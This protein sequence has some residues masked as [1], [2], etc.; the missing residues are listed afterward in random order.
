MIDFKAKM[1]EENN[2]ISN[3]E[4]LKTKKRF[5][6][7]ASFIVIIFL[8][9]SG[10]VIMSSPQASTW[11]QEHTFLGKIKYLSESSERA[12]LG[13]KEDRINIL[14]L[15]TG[16]EGHDGANLADT[17]M[18]VS[19]KPSTQE[20]ALISFPRD[21]T[22]PVKGLNTW[23][24]INSLNA[25]GEARSKGDGAQ[26][27]ASNLSQIFNL[28]INYFIRVDFNTFVNIIDL[29]NG[30]TVDVENT[31]SDYK[32]PISG[33]EDNPDYYARFEHL[34]I[35]KGEQKMDGNLALKFVRSRHASGIEG[36]D[37]ARARRQQLVLEAIKQNLLSQEML[38]KPNTIS[39]IIKEL[40]RGINTNLNV[41]ELIKLWNMFKDVN[42]ENIAN[43]VF[44]DGPN[45]YLRASRGEQNAFIL[46][47]KSGNFSEMQMVIH[48]IFKEEE[49]LIIEEEQE[50][51]LVNKVKISVI[52]GS[53]KTGLAANT[54]A[55]LERAGF[56]IIDVAN[57]NTRD[58]QTNQI[59]DLNFGRFNSELEKLLTIIDAEMAFDAPNWI[60]EYKEG[61]KQSDF[62]LILGAN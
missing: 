21:L 58:Y 55:T 50:E 23:R 33:Q 43:F 20:V 56:E 39:K 28:D 27:T 4:I 44:D 10:K 8:I 19:F 53:W 47:P 61:D 62:V 40:D 57:A 31:L 37:F 26:F 1:Q 42:K 34:Y 2:D 59:Y 46:I 45:N 29:L 11:L 18:L 54:A 35:E 51:I 5:R 17:I 16:G 30:I 9:F 52:N 15:G 7:I 3:P 24:K 36:N 32:Y 12:L 13:E 25:I 48:N 38:L 14:L 49:N 22:V 41:W 6:F 60:N